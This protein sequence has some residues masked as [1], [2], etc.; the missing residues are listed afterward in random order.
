MGD[1][2]NSSRALILWQDPQD[3]IRAAQSNVK[4]TVKVDLRP[5]VDCPLD[6]L[7]TKI[8]LLYLYADRTPVQKA[9][10]VLETAPRTTVMAGPLQDGAITLTVPKGQSYHYYFHHD[11]LRDGSL[12]DFFPR[13]LVQLG[14][15]TDQVPQWPS[16]VAAQGFAKKLRMHWGDSEFHKNPDDH[17]IP[18]LEKLVHYVIAKVMPAPGNG[19]LQ[20][21]AAWLIEALILTESIPGGGDSVDLWK[22][23]VFNRLG[24]ALGPR[25]RVLQGLLQFLHATSGMAAQTVLQAA[26]DGMND[27][28]KGNAVDWLR[29]FGGQAQA[30]ESGVAGHIANLFTALDAELSRIVLASQDQAWAHNTNRATRWRTGLRRLPLPAQKVNSV[31]GNLWQALNALVA[32]HPAL[33]YHLPG[34]LEQW[35]T[36]RQTAAPFPTYRPA[37]VVLPVTWFE[38]QYQ[39][40]DGTPVEKASFL[41]RNQSK[42]QIAADAVGPDGIGYIEAPVGTSYEFRFHADEAELQ[43]KDPD[44]A[45]QREPDGKTWL[46]STIDGGHL[47]EGKASCR[48]S[49]DSDVS[50]LE[51]FQGNPTYGRLLHL[52]LIAHGLPRRTAETEDDKAAEKTLV[53]IIRT[54]LFAGKLA[55]SEKDRLWRG[56][57]LHR[58]YAV[59]DPEGVAVERLLALLE[60]R[61]DLKLSEV[62]KWLNSSGKG[63]AYK[64][65]EKLGKD[66]PAMRKTVA[67][68]LQAVLDGFAAEIGKIATEGPKIGVL[69]RLSAGC[70]K[71]R[72]DPLP[73]VEEALSSAWNTIEERLQKLIA[74][75]EDLKGFQPVAKLMD[76]NPYKQVSEPWPAR[77]PLQLPDPGWVELLFAYAD[78]TP[79]HKAAY[80]VTVGAALSG[81]TA[82][83]YAF[84]IVDKGKT[85]KYELTTDEKDF[86]ILE[87][88]KGK[89][90][91]EAFGAGM[92]DSALAADCFKAGKPAVTWGASHFTSAENFKLAPTVSQIASAAVRSNSPITVG[93]ADNSHEELTLLLYPLLMGHLLPDETGDRLNADE[94]QAIWNAVCFHWA[95]QV[96]GPAGPVIR[97][98][99]Y[100]LHV[101]DNPP[102]DAAI[103]KLYGVGQG[104]A[105]RWLAKLLGEMDGVQTKVG[106]SLKAICQAISTEVKKIGDAPDVK[107]APGNKGLA[108]DAVA[109]IAVVVGKIDAAVIGA[110]Q[111]SRARLEALSELDEPVYDG[112]AAVCELTICRLQQEKL[113]ARPPAVA[114]VL[115]WVE[116]E[117]L[118]HDDKPVAGAR[119]KVVKEL[120]PSAVLYTGKLADGYAYLIVPHDLKFKYY[121]HGENAFVLDPV[122]NLNANNVPAIPN[123]IRVAVLLKKFKKSKLGWGSCSFSDRMDFQRSPSVGRIACHVIRAA[124]MTQHCAAD[125]PE[126]EELAKM[127]HPILMRQ[128]ANS[129]NALL[130][131]KDNTEFWTAAVLNRIAVLLGAEG[132]VI[133]NLLGAM[134]AACPRTALGAVDVPNILKKTNFLE[135]LN[136]LGV[137][138][139]VTWLQTLDPLRDPNKNAVQT[140]L[141]TIFDRLTAELTE[142]EK[143]YTVH[144]KLQSDAALKY[145]ASV[146]AR[147]LAVKPDIAVQ[148]LRVF[149]QLRE[150]LAAILGQPRVPS[151]GALLTKNTLK[152]TRTVLPAHVTPAIPRWVEM[153]YCYPKLDP[154]APAE[155]ALRKHAGGALVK[156]GNLDA[157]G[158]VYVTDLPVDA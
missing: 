97:D 83:G 48:W 19:A 16:D 69:S 57:S 138:H 18:V 43:I 106:D 115:D 98:F 51:M 109:R 25:S 103:R 149:T 129:V 130:A 110:F 66:L 32:D 40:A 108:K 153:S 154:V 62:V 100:W 88:K 67:G 155:Y 150:E 54:L 142:L 146:K 44:R 27:A 9:S 117:Y 157:N 85:Y 17:A 24:V 5:V 47:E 31:L 118:H 111:K 8:L 42:A 144:R 81:K 135:Y 134:H 75:K 39:Y 114:P 46:G 104:N 90:K 143:Q 123:L 70:L 52:Q 99:L 139:G 105:H 35:N 58:L 4:L 127:L 82:G 133:A 28:G 26:I 86:E 102:R 92:V 11:G 10:F 158:F 84:E 152:Q 68:N 6:K 136:S 13:A 23:L 156:G 128:P 124:E 72:I 121:F 65:I 14:P 59:S 112:D 2:G 125:A 91:K 71:K 1:G 38:I 12:F 116:L 78:G 80:K 137:G 147:I 41:V 20:I 3:I 63:N 95:G 21:E 45:A 37:P 49:E 120:D 113:D 89:E 122:A 74:A 107:V 140:N 101:T 76:L 33:T 126:A 29:A 55:T 93:D 151:G 73:K 22:R 7:N 145:A 148:V 50:S 87:S 60:T 96:L 119:Y 53:G 79:V 131:Y 132:A 64:W 34:H 77:P 141:E 36:L 15:A 56:A 94:F 30:I 61:E